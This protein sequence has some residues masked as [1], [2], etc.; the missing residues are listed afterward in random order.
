[1]RQAASALLWRLANALADTGKW[2]LLEG[3]TAPRSPN[4]TSPAGLRRYSATSIAS[5]RTATRV[6]G[7]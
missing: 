3:S 4:P 6:G 1:M 7:G 5:P 2:F